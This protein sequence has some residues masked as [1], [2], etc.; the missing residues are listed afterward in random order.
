VESTILRGHVDKKTE[1]LKCWVILDA[2]DPNLGPDLKKSISRAG[3]E[4]FAIRSNAQAAHTVVVT[5]E[6]VNQDAF[7]RIPNIAVVIVV[8]GKENT[9]SD[10]EGDR[11]DST[12]NFVV[13]KFVELLVSTDVKKS[14]RAVIT[15]RAESV[16]VWEELDR[17]DVRLVTR[18]SLHTIFACSVIP[19]LGRGITASTDEVLF[20]LPDAYRHHITS[21]V[22]EDRFGLFLLDIPQNTGAVTRR[23]DDFVFFDKSATRQIPFMLG[24]FSVGFLLSTTI[25]SD[26]EFVHGAEV[27]KTSTSYQSS[28]G[29]VG[30]GHHPG[31][32]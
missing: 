15:A 10:G 30:A 5:D 4:S 21:V 2:L 31:R 24:Q 18:E 28:L 16:T 22:V 1:K 8:A 23:S 17:V 13:R 29:R 26:R 7:L 25:L 14:A 20:V 6:L 11:G 3:A 19:Q 12:Q 27:V 32:A 9:P